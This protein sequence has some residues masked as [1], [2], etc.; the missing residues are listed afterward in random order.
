[1]AVCYIEN[2]N[3]PTLFGL[4]IEGLAG[5][6]GLAGLRVSCVTVSVG[7]DVAMFKLKPRSVALPSWRSLLLQIASFNPFRSPSQPSQHINQKP[8]DGEELIHHFPDALTKH[9]CFFIVFYNY[10]VATTT[11]TLYTRIPSGVQAKFIMSK[12]SSLSPLYPICTRHPFLHYN[13]SNS[14]FPLSP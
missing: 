1:M 6:A 5:L 14:Q 4:R 9:Y 10:S 8:K 12:A 7:C 2:C 3:I 13:C 11:P